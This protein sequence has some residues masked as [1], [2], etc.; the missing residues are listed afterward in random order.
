V[1]PVGRRERFG[2]SLTETTRK[3]VPSWLRV[4]ELE[5]KTSSRPSQGNPS[6]ETNEKTTS[7]WA[8]TV[9]KSEPKQERTAWEASVYPNPTK[10]KSWAR[11]LLVNA[12]GHHGEKKSIEKVKE[13]KKT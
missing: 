10:K 3:K 5:K 2:E 4:K 11:L 8:R 6:R 9:Q 7:P 1:E 12:V 13:K